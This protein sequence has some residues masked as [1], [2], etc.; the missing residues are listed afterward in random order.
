MGFFKDYDYFIKIIFLIKKKLIY[1]YH[2]FNQ[3]NNFTV[4]WELKL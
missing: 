4:V 1:F 3:E 2:N